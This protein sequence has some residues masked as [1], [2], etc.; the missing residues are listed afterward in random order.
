MTWVDARTRAEVPGELL[1][2]VYDAV[3]EGDGFGRALLDV[4]D[5]VVPSDVATFNRTDIDARRTD[6]DVHPVPHAQ[7]RDRNDDFVRL[8]DEHPL[9]RRFAT[10]EVPPPMRWRDVVDPSAFERTELFDVYYRPMGVTHQLAVKLAG[11]GTGM[12]TIALSRSRRPFTDDERDRLAAV[13]PHLRRSCRVHRMLG[14]GLPTVDALIAGGLTSRQAEVALALS[15]GGTNPELARRLGVSLGTL[16]KHLE[17]IYGVLGV[18]N[19]GAAIAAIR[20]FGR[21]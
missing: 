10:V 12:T 18:D 3:D 13:L 11:S 7:H 5:R 1:A 20:S 21:R 16:R 15:G 2:D 9:I 19:R 8:H 17:R 4:V 6:F 14:D